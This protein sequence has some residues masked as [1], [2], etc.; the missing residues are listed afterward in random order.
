MNDGCFKEEICSKCTN[1]MTIPNCFK[2]RVYTGSDE[3]PDFSLK[4]DTVTANWKAAQKRFS[5]PE[6]DWVVRDKEPL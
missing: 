4:G 2:C 1:F 3:G 5:Q 6:G